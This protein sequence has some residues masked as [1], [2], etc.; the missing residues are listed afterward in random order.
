MTRLVRRIVFG[1]TYDAFPGLLIV[2]CNQ[3]KRK[4]ERAGFAVTV[5]TAPLSALPPDTDIVF[6]PLALADVARQAASQCRIEVLDELLNHPS[7]NILVA[8][9]MDGSEWTALPAAP[10]ADPAA[11]TIQTYR[12]SLRID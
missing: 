11:G 4:L 6:V 3:L 2:A 8:Q 5:E 12:G 9:L 1:Y 7:Y 10:P